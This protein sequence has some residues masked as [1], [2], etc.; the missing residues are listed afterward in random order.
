MIGP[1]Q[2]AVGA[3]GA[4]TGI[5]AVFT[6][7]RTKRAESWPTVE[8]Q[9]VHAPPQSMW[10]NMRRLSRWNFE[11]D[12]CLEWHVDGQTYRRQLDNDRELKVAGMPVW[13]DPPR[14]A[15]QVVSYN[16]NDPGSVVLA[17]EHGSW[18]IYGLICL[19]CFVALTMS[20]F[21]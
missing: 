12:Y 6:A 13:V 16:P 20:L 10:Q 21:V 18:K 4:G 11:S 7:I 5:T 9:V 15:P 3:L 2:F 14:Q 8:A 19:G 17:A 1:F